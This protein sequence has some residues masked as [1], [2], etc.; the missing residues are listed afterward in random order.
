MLLGNVK[1]IIGLVVMVDEGN[2]GK[3]KSKIYQFNQFCIKY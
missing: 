1:L 2:Q 3:G